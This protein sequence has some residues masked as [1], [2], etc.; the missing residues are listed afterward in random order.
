[1]SERETERSSTV[2]GT[3]LRAFSSGKVT[4]RSTSRALSPG[5]SV[6]TETWIDEMSGIASIGRDL[7]ARTPAPSMATRRMIMTRRRRIDR[8][9]R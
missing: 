9:T 3:P 2:P 6:S 8:F 5:A 4:E 7:A 1:M